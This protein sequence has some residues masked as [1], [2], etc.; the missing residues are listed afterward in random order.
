MKAYIFQ[1][2]FMYNQMQHILKHNC[3]YVNRALVD[4]NILRQYLNYLS[5]KPSTI[6]EFGLA[7]MQVLG[8][9]GEFESQLSI[10]K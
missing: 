8:E 1:I 6:P 9:V 5:A 7:L 4:I 3:L 2:T 10:K